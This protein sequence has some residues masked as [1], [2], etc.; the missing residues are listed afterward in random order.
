[1]AQAE[2]CSAAGAVPV[3]RYARRS[4]SIVVR[5]LASPGVRFR[6]DSGR[7]GGRS[8]WRAVRQGSVAS[9]GCV[10]RLW[11]MRITGRMRRRWLRS[12]GFRLAPGAGRGCRASFP[13]E[14]I[15]E[16][17]RAGRR[18]R[19][20]LSALRAR[21][22]QTGTDAL[23]RAGGMR[24]NRDHSPTAGGGRARA[25]TGNRY[26]GMGDPVPRDAG[27]G[28]DPAAVNSAAPTGRRGAA[29]Q[30]VPLPKPTGRPSGSYCGNRR[31]RPVVVAPALVKQ[32]PGVG[33]WGRSGV[34]RWNAACHINARLLVG[35]PP[36]GVGRQRP[37]PPR[38]PPAPCRSAPPR[39]WSAPA[40]VLPGSAS[41]RCHAVPLLGD[42]HL[43]NAVFEETVR[44]EPSMTLLA[45]EF[46]LQER[47]ALTMSMT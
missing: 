4:C 33:A 37:P 46:A 43:P 14:E 20:G 8:C 12:G 45:M 22:G 38:L 16:A 23:R 9:G 35:Q 34:A 3:C 6:A 27:S 30:R 47:R 41:S 2:R 17:P 40:R 18:V 25:A 39:R 11:P 26:A 7:C 5:P 15:G 21:R 44:L 13:P 19:R 24:P 42:P 10:R 31:L 1:M 29:P 28:C 32:V 36:P